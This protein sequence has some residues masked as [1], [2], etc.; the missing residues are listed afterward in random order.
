MRGSNARGT[1]AV[2]KAVR[3]RAAR[4][5]LLHTLNSLYTRRHPFMGSTVC[6]VELGGKSQATFLR[7]FN[8]C[9]MEKGQLGCQW[10]GEAISSSNRERET[11]TSC[12]SSTRVTFLT[13][14][15]K[16]PK[17]L[18]LIVKTHY[19]PI[20]CATSR[21][22]LFRKWRLFIYFYLSAVKRHLPHSHTHKTQSLAT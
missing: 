5:A 3:I 15:T 20:Y 16:I 21:I 2:S 6:A 14:F 12:F 13:P 1:L 17:N 8:T 10:Q 18:H 9:E 22:L 7:I 4:K 19:S 11:Y